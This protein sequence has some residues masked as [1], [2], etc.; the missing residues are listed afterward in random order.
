MFCGHK[1]VERRKCERIPVTSPNPSIPAIILIFRKAHAPSHDLQD[2]CLSYLTSHHLLLFITQ[3]LGTRIFLFLSVLASLSLAY[4]TYKFILRT[5][6]VPFWCLSPT[7][8]SG[9]QMRKAHRV[10]KYKLKSG[11]SKDRIQYKARCKEGET[12]MVLG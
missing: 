10:L 7:H 2:L 9:L 11:N 1:K 6:L 3:H 5:F 4:L 8:P 12:R